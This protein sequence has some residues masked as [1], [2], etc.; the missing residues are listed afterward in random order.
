[1]FLI[2]CLS[3]SQVFGDSLRN[4]V[5][6]S[7]RLAGLAKCIT[8][9]GWVMYSSFTCSA[10]RAQIKLFGP[11]ADY[12]KIIE[13]NPHDPD[14]QAQLCL[15]KGIRYT[16]TWLLDK[17]GTEIKRVKGYKKLNDLAVLTGCAQ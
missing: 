6:S 12:L 2:F 11:A 7:G 5:D 15:K 14:T 17:N 1:M 13:C 3:P 10:C 9:K 4:H 16:P 8:E